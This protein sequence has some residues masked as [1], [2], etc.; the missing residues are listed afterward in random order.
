M[1]E[2]SS[3]KDAVLAAVPNATVMPARNS[4]YPITVAVVDNA[5]GSTL[6]TGRFAT[7]Q[8]VTPRALGLSQTMRI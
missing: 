4:S 2:F 5:S 6:W 3:V 8:R 7:M 1:Q